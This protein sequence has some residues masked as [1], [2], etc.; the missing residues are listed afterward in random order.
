MAVDSSVAKGFYNRGSGEGQ[1]QYISP[2]DAQD[3]IQKIYDD[4]NSE[5]SK[6][7][8]T[9]GFEDEVYVGPTPPPDPFYGQLWIELP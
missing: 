2:K 9:S 3:A 6:I 1:N 5:I 4:L 8:G 7:V